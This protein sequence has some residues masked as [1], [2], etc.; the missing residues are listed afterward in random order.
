MDT[1]LNYPVIWRCRPDKL[2]F[3]KNL[4]CLKNPVVLGCQFCRQYE[5]VVVISRKNGYAI[6]ITQQYECDVF[7]SQQ[8]G[9]FLYYYLKL[10]QE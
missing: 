9:D 4:Y 6:Q 7:V 5:D 8:Y 10:L 2:T 3:K 1:G